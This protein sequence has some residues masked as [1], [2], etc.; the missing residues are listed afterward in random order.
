[1]AAFFLFGSGVAVI[2]NFVSL[3]VMTDCVRNITITNI[4]SVLVYCLQFKNVDIPKTLEVAHILVT[5][6]VLQ[7]SCS[8]AT[9]NVMSAF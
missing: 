1:M 6:L 7:K 3:S 2:E 8:G 5:R 9:I 4:P